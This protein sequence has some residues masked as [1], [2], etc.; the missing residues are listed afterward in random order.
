M[1]GTSRG[2]AEPINTMQTTDDIKGNGSI[3]VMKIKEWCLPRLG[4]LKPIH[5][6]RHFTPNMFTS[7]GIQMNCGGHGLLYHIPRN[8]WDLAYER[9]RNPGKHKDQLS[10]GVRALRR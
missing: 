7:L 1:R 5:P 6:D 3:A 9:Q 4:P 8:T 10:E 2:E